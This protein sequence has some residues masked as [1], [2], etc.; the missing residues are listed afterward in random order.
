MQ[1]H[2]AVRHVT[3]GAGDMLGREISESDLAD[4]PSGLGLSGEKRRHAGPTIAHRPTPRLV[5]ID[6][7]SDMPIDCGMALS[8][9]AERTCIFVGS[10]RKDLSEMPD[11]VKVRFAEVVYVLHAFQKT[12]KSGIATPKHV[13]TMVASRLKDAEAM[14][15]AAMKAGE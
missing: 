15:Q 8:A 11:G 2:E 12:S 7:Y 3:R 5:L 10:S 4:V 13:M 14:H 1:Q 9:M 6:I